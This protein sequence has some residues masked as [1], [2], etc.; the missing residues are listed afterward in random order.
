MKIKKCTSCGFSKIWSKSLCK[1][2]FL[3]ANP[4]KKIQY[5]SAK[6]KIKDVDKTQR[7]EE[8]H[9]WFLE[10]WNKRREWDGRRFVVK[11]FE[12]GYFLDEQTFK[13]NTCCYSH[14]FPK[15]KYPQYAL[16]EWNLEIVKP[17]IHAL[18]ENDHSKCPRMY[19]KW[20]KLKEKYD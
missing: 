10:V 20:L 9:Q 7:T 13:Y 8:L 3:N 15:S 12:S 5:K 11:C 2:C 18:W 1:I 4:P 17:D 6:Q 16:E 14:Y 19:E